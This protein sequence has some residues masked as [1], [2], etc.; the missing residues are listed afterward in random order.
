MLGWFMVSAQ[1]VRNVVGADLLG[2]RLIKVG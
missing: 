1:R 2:I